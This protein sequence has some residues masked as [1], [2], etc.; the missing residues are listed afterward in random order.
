M[1]RLELISEIGKGRKVFAKEDFSNRD[2]SGLDL[3]GMD[4]R[5]SNFTNANLSNTILTNCILVVANLQGANLSG[6]VIDGVDF[7][8]VLNA[9]TATFKGAIYNGEPLEE[10]VTVDKLG[11]YQ[12]LVSDKFIQIGCLKGNPT[13]WKT[14]NATKLETEMDKINPNEKAD[15]EAWRQTHLAK[16]ITDHENKKPKGPK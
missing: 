3:T 15:A 8:L 7:E 10:N 9:D 4:L 11:K 12:R 5:R 6:A 16:T 1:T 14:L 13:F 2:L